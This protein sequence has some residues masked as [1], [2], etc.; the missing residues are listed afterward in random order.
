MSKTSP[1]PGGDQLPEDALYAA[2]LFGA[3]GQE[4][5][6]RPETKAPPKPGP[7]P[8]GEAETP[9]PWTEGP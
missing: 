3:K 7:H 5:K 1:K 2:N 8:D 9:D 6:V 4:L